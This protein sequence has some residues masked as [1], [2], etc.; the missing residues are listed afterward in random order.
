MSMNGIGQK[1]AVGFVAFALSVRMIEFAIP[2]LALRAISSSSDS[3]SIYVP[4][5]GPFVTQRL[6]SA[7]G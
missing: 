4:R 6:G 2:A 1:G 7:A 5:G 3:D